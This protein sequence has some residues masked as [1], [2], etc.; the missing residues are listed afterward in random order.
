MLQGRLFSYLDTQI[1]RLGGP[2]FQQ[3]PI[4]RPLAPVNNNQRDGMHRMTIDMGQTSYYPNALNRNEPHAADQ[5]D[6]HFSHYQEKIDGNI[7]RERSESFRDHYTQA[8]MFWNSMATHEKAHI[9]DAFSFELGKCKNKNTRQ[10]IV[11]MLTSVNV[12]LA[13]AVGD[14][15]GI[16]PKVGI[17]ASPN[18]MSSPALSIDNTAKSPKTTKTAVILEPGFDR[19]QYDA[20][21]TAITQAGGKFDVISKILAPISASDQSTV[22]SGQTYATAAS[23]TYDAVFVPGG[24]HIDTLKLSGDVVHFLHEAYK[25]FKTVALGGDASELFAMDARSNAAPEDDLTAGVVTLDPNKD[26]SHFTNAFISALTQG[27]HF[28]RGSIVTV[29]SA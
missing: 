24:K 19:A 6:S 12:D 27:R 29:V 21:T 13:K 4:N 5:G 14:K 1:S 11:N 2:N 3:I 17:A 10:A 25:H 28:Q 7:I 23:V 15:L 18:P 8:A 9:V 16:T 22:N 20:I 26:L